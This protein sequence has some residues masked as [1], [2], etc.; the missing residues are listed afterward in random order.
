MLVLGRR[1]ANGLKRPNKKQE[2]KKE[3]KKRRGGEKAIGDS[4]KRSARVW[5]R[6]A[7]RQ[8]RGKKGKGGRDW[9]LET[10]RLIRY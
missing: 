10:E 7:W 5:R 8:K 9:R 3:E 6:G 4:V 2:A 1:H